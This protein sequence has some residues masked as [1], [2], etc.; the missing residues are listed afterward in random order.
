MSKP[1]IPISKKVLLTVEEAA[2]YSGIDI[3][4]LR[5]MTN[6][7]HCKLVVRNGS[8]RLIKRCQID[9]YLYEADSIQY[10]DCLSSIT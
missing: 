1:E 8:K 3:N 7:K 4:K 5:E 2:A 10:S 9:E 6:E